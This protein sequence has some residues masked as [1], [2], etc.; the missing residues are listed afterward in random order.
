MPWADD[1]SGN[2]RKQYNAH[3]NVY[4]RLCRKY[5]VLSTYLTVN[6]RRNIL[7]ASVQRHPHAS[8]S[9][10]LEALAGGL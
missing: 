4:E 3:M 1:V 9:E 2:Q 6:W 7:F 5:Q 8:L 10:Q